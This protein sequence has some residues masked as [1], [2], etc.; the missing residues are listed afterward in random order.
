M[1]LICLDRSSVEV[2]RK[3][4]RWELGMQSTMGDVFSLSKG[5]VSNVTTGGRRVFRLLISRRGDVYCAKPDVV[6][7]NLS[8]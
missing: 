1:S 3:K 6:S 7:K 5:T 8:A 4:H 2:W